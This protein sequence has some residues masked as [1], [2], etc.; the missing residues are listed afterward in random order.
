MTSS[1]MPTYEDPSPNEESLD[2]RKVA[3]MLLARAW[4]I[5]VCLILS[6]GVT[7]LYL[8]RAVP[9]Y[10]ATAVLAYQ[11]DQLRPMDVSGLTPEN[12]PAQLLET[13]LRPIGRELQSLRFLQRVADARK[14]AGDPR[15]H[16]PEPGK[17]FTT[18]DAAR[19][20][21]RIVSLDLPRNDNV[22]LVTAEH[23]DPN[24]AADLANAI[25]Q[26]YIQQ[27]EE[28]RSTAIEAA[29]LNL[30]AIMNSLR[31]EWEAMEE[32]MEP[33]RETADDLSRDLVFQS[34]MTHQLV[35]ESI[36]LANR[37]LAIEGS[38]KQIDEGKNDISRLLNI[39]II[40]ADDDVRACKQAVLQS[41]LAL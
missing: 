3:S 7:F 12:T 21:S 31:S 29:R 37:I 11:I 1:N 2:F 19:H 27:T 23:T 15:F 40:A 35:Q 17:P 10:T 5:V 39:S 9:R 26:E 4:I 30:Q 33:I 36:Q 13:R 41:E 16:T 14:L 22:I 25:V 18:E 20:L 28:N 6:V 8:Y 34:Q 24:V 38:S 32:K